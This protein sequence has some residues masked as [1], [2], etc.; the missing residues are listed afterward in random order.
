MFDQPLGKKKKKKASWCPFWISLDV[1]LKH[2]YT[3]HHWIPR[4]RV[5]HLPLHFPSSGRS[6]EQESKFGVQSDPQV[7]NSIRE[8]KRLQITLVVLIYNIPC[9]IRHMPEENKMSPSFPWD[10]SW[11]MEMGECFFSVWYAALF[12]DILQYLEKQ[13]MYTKGTAKNFTI[14][15]QKVKVESVHHNFLSLVFCSA[16]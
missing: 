6:R 8:S 5:L 2:S 9:V 3:F 14:K 10:S 13:N 7:W 15:R 11:R 16:I 12:E 4:G 1:T